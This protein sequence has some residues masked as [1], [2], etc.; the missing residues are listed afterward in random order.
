VKPLDVTWRQVV[1]WRMRKQLL[2]EPAGDL[3]A[4]ARRLCGVHAQVGSCAAL[5]AGVRTAAP[6]DPGTALW[7]DRSL[8]RTWAMRGTLHL[9]PA[10]ELDLWVSALT[11]RESRRR[12]PP[13]WERTHGVTAAQLHAITDAVGAVLGATPLRRSELAEAVC[14]H[15]GDPALLEPLS[16]GWGALL[17]PAAARG[18]LCS[19]PVVDGAVTFVSPAA[20]RGTPLAAVDP[21][22]AKREVLSR[23][24]ASTGPATAADLAHWWGEEP[25]PAK[26]L[27]RENA[28]A[29][30]PVAVDGEA[31][32]MV[33]AEDAGEL[34]ATPDGG[35]DPA[36]TCVL[37]P[38][39][40]P[41]VIAP[42]SHRRRAVPEGRASAVSRTAG[43]I[44][45]VL[46]VDGAVAGVWQH[47]V[48]RRL[49]TI[50]VTTFG[51]LTA[52]ERRVTQD[53]ARRYGALLG[54]DRVDLVWAD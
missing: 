26:R 8:V 4:V 3:V 32:Y 16:T 6:A 35:R 42:L 53:Y 38:A 37:L 11:D 24:L 45:P 51:S 15:L 29:L 41:W 5:I 49:L 43:W 39:F 31:G 46:V 22:A 40:D 17:K 1:R 50:T 36:D 9:L 10:D 18:L 20:W 48:A 30:A 23:F 34:V 28:D 2:L 12:F 7:T 13:S 14:A 54:T 21:A 52:D 33:R 44:S 19:G 25:A 27:L 47:A